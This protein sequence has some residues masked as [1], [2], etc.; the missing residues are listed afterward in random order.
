M[1]DVLVASDRNVAIVVRMC[2]VSFLT[3]SLLVLRAS[4]R[5]VATHTKFRSRLLL[6]GSVLLH[7]VLDDEDVILDNSDVF[8][9]SKTH[10]RNEE[11]ISEFVPSSPESAPVSP[12]KKKVK[13]EDDAYPLGEYSKER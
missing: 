9:A 3:L 11:V 7:S 12:V 10:E 8:V 6:A 13:R 1:D 2:S 5:N 4:D